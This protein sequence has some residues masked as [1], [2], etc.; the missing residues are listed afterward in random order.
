MRVCTCSTGRPQTCPAHRYLYDLSLPDP[1]DGTQ[2]GFV[3]GYDTSADEADQA[4][5][6]RKAGQR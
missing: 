5:W 2:G 1:Y 6:E 4:R 3:P